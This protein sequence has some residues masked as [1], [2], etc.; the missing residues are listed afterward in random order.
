MNMMKLILIC[1]TLLAFSAH[2]LSAK[3]VL[4]PSHRDQPQ[5]LSEPNELKTL[6]TYVIPQNGD[7]SIPELFFKNQAGETV[8]LSDYFEDD[9]PVVL[10]MIYIHCPKL[11]TEVL[12]GTTRALQSLSLSPGKN[13]RILTVSFNPEEGN[14]HGLA[15]SLRANYVDA[16]RAKDKHGRRDFNDKA[17]DVL[18]EQSANDAN[19]KGNAYLLCNMLD[20]QYAYNDNSGLFEHA[21]MTVFISPKGKI[22]RYLYGTQYSAKDMKLAIM[23]ASKGN[24]EL[25]AVENFISWCYSYDPKSKGYTPAVLKIMTCAA[26]LSILM[27]ASFMFVMWRKEHRNGSIK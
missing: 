5:G 6:G 26:G 3:S 15:A 19:Y 9:I 10:N 2:S 25:S 4:D 18:V 27:F 20:F 16:F 22:T 8:K 24:K 17:W 13:Y 21:S 14:N 7:K 1:L 12:N 23:E 11:C